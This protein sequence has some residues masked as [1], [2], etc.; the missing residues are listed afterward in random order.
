MIRGQV[1]CDGQTVRADEQQ[2]MTILANLHVIAG[3]YPGPMLDLLGLVRI[4]PARAQGPLQLVKVVGQSQGNAFRHLLIWVRSS[5]CLTRV[6]VNQPRNSLDAI[7]CWYSHF[8]KN[9][10]IPSV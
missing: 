6:R 2:A 8:D 5:P 10:L 3:T 1:F 7:R 4:K 9:L